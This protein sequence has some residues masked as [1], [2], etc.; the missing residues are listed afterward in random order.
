MNFYMNEEYV[1]KVVRG[2]WKIHKLGTGPLKLILNFQIG[3]VLNTVITLNDSDGAVLSVARKYWTF[4]LY[5]VAHICLIKI[6]TGT[7]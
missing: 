4:L 5:F 7:K 2:K 3:C 1:E 6:T